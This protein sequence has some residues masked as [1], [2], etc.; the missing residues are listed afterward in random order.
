MVCV[1][2]CLP[3]FYSPTKTTVYQNQVLGRPQIYFKLKNVSTKERVL[4]ESGTETSTIGS[5][6][7]GCGFWTGFLAMLI[8][9]MYDNRCVNTRIDRRLS[10][11]LLNSPEFSFIMNRLVSISILLNHTSSYSSPFV[12]K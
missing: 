9:R 11:K 8:D 4:E 5:L 7:S 1:V 3:Y 6:I 2:F 12:N 10:F